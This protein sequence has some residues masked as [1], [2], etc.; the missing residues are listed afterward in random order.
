MGQVSL[1]GIK[2]TSIVHVGNWWGAIQP[3]LT[4]ADH[5]DVEAF[6]FIAD[7]HAL[8]TIHSAAEL[9]ELTYSVTAAWLAFGLDPERST[10]YRQSDVPEVYE[11]SWLLACMTS[12]GWM[13]KAHAYKAIRDRNLAESKD[14]D[15]GVNMGLYTYPIL[16][17]ADIMIVDADVV[18]V[19]KDQVQHVEIARDMADRVNRLFAKGDDV[20]LK[21]PK[22]ELRSHG[23]LVLGLDGEKMSKSRGNTIQCF[24]TQKKLRKLVMGIQTDSTPP[25]APKD[26]ESSLVYAIHACFLNEAEQ[27]ALADQYRAGISWGGAK[28]ALFETLDGHLAGPREHYHALMDDKSALD[29]IL[30]T[31]AARARERT[32][33]VIARVRGAMGY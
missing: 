14:P 6:Y 3:A 19:G 21:P 29:A 18:P 33:A 15:D 9:R 7:G 23:N 13:N 25:E 30:A 8:T 11:L 28:Q 22:A 12:K 26:P 16:M 4:L 32:R 20:V 27:A 31:G 24:L 1:T 17:A 10:L 5:D 2:P